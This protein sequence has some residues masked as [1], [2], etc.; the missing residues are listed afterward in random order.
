MSD[1]PIDKDD[2]VER[3]RSGICAERCRVMNKASGCECAEAAGEIELLRNALHDAYDKIVKYHKAVGGEYPGGVPNMVLL[4]QIR[5][6]L[7]IEK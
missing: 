3:L 7:G 6:I 2:L 4:P 1:T 5:Q